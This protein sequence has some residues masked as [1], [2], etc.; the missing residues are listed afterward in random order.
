MGSDYNDYYLR[1]KKNIDNKTNTFVSFNKEKEPYYGKPLI[2]SIEKL[3]N[4]IETYDKTIWVVADYKLYSS[5]STDF[6]KFI[7][8]E[9]KVVFDNTQK[10]KAKVFSKVK[11]K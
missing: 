4:L 5:V 3:Q 10:N 2:D 6:I 11:N 7:N 9:F 1:Q 8:K